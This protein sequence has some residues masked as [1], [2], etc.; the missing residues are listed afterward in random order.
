MR[1]FYLAFLCL[2]A[3]ATLM[4]ACTGDDSAE[5]CD[6]QCRDDHTAFAIIDGTFKVIADSGFLD[7]PVGPVDATAPCELGGS[8]H[9][10]GLTSV[11]GDVFTWNLALDYAD[12]GLTGDSYQLKLGGALTLTGSYSNAESN[13]FTDFTY[14]SPALTMSGSVITGKPNIDQTC[15]VLLRFQVKDGAVLPTEGTI[16]GRTVGSTPSTSGSGGGPPDDACAPYTGSYAGIFSMQWSCPD[17]TMDGLGT[18]NV[19]FTARCFYAM[20]DVVVLEVRKI[21][22]DNTALGALTE[23]SCAEDD[24]A[25]DFGLLRMPPNPPATSGAD[26]YLDLTFPNL[27]KLTTSGPFTVTTGAAKIGNDV[28]NTESFLVGIPVEQAAGRPDGCTTHTYTFKIDK[29]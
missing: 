27:T 13:T 28:P 25:C 9:I 3:F 29:L 20:D 23:E 2:F 16:C 6:Q 19:H 7:Q 12:C 18:I 17:P 1:A 22:S 10:T 26:H 5:L 24:L 15:D 8:A 4:A 21:M 11:A 14:S